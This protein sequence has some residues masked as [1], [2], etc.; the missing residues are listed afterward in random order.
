M[1]HDKKIKILIS[2]GGTGGHVV[3]AKHIASLLLSRCCE[4][5][6]ASH[7]I[8]K[9]PYLNMEFLCEDIL[10]SPF[11]LKGKKGLIFF[12][13][14]I[15]GIFQSYKL[16]KKFNPDVIVGF[17]SFYTFSLMLTAKLMRK[18][19]VIFE[20]NTIFGK[21]N[22]YFS[23]YA[24]VVACQFPILPFNKNYKLINLMPFN[25]SNENTKTNNT[26]TIL[27]FGGSQGAK[28]INDLLY[29]AAEIIS[30]ENIELRII[31]IAGSKEE[32]IRLEKHYCSLKI[33]HLVMEFCNNMKDMYSQADIVISRSGAATIGELLSYEIPSILIPYPFSKDMH[34]KYNAEFMKNEIKA[35][36]CFEQKD[37]DEN[38][39]LKAIIDLFAENRKKILLMKSNIKKYKVSREEHNFLE[40]IIDVAKDVL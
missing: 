37:V 10:S 34:Q 35:A 5:K 19:I 38:I 21:V 6:F 36:L 27:V 15:L 4:V 8:S 29:K 18:K 40:L 12:K 23:S 24:K 11:T 26:T 17:G 20:S 33:N 14:L 32:K 22:N 16:L 25:Y 28:F 39:L 7:K 9:N 13:N 31:H 3:P 30:S 1:N 2:A